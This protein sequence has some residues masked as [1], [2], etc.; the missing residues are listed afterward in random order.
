MDPHQG[1]KLVTTHGALQANLSGQDLEGPDLEALDAPWRIFL[2]ILYSLTAIVS[3]VLN[4]ITIIVLVRGRRNTHEM[5]KYLINLS[6]SDL[7]MSCFSILTLSVFVSVST[8]IA[9]GINS[10]FL[11]T[12]A[13]PLLLLCYLY[14]AI[15]MK[16]WRHQMPGN[17]DANRDFN[18]QFV[19]IKV[20]KMLAV[21]VIVFA[22]F[23]L[24]LQLFSLIIYLCPTI[25]EGVVYKS[26]PYNIFVATYFTCHW[27]GMAHSCL[28]PLI[29][30]FMNDNFKYDLKS[31]CSQALGRPVLSNGHHSMH[32]S[33]N[34]HN[35]LKQNSANDLP[36]QPINNNNC[37]ANNNNSNTAT[38][39]NNATDNSTNNN[40][41]NC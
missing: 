5:R 31:V 28:N 35:A 36:L 26:T 39:D 22:V 30:C 2:V 16:I 8:M 1:Y 13:I 33:I 4:V 37:G 3:F 23:W 20:I 21:V 9:I 25:R 29:Y 27:L 11:V 41:S 14:S 17:A 6:V 12:F 10:I 19:R 40:N 24:P 18:Q 32:K 38:N 34:S 15:C 7:L